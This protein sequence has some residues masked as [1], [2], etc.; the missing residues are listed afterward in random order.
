MSKW[1][2]SMLAETV[3]V[4]PVVAADWTAIA[5]LEHSVYGPKGLSEGREVLESRASASPETCFVLTAGHWIAGYVLA[6]PYPEGQFPDLTEPEAAGRTSRN[7][8]LHDLAIAAAFR[9]SGLARRLLRH[10]TATALSREHDRISLIAV[11]GSATFW[12]ANGFQPNPGIAVPT[13]Y[14][15]N[16]VYMSKAI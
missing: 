11:A 4:R 12:S 3:C 13:G 9:G 8:H 14:G 6:M 15:G 10:L 5:E 7:L 16:A 1:H 2:T